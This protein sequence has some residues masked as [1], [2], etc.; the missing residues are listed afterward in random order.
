[1]NGQVD[2]WM[3]EHV[4]GEQIPST[5][6]PVQRLPS[7]AVAAGAQWGLRLTGGGVE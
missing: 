6:L 2:G 5:W 1:M 7:S 3:D 4:N